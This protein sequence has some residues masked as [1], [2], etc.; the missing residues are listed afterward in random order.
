MAQR[1]LPQPQSSFETSLYIKVMVHHKK[2]TSVQ[3]KVCTQKQYHVPSAYLERWKNAQKRVSKQYCRFDS[4]KQQKKRGSYNARQSV[5]KNGKLHSKPEITMYD[6][7][8]MQP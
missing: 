1:A 4:L 7:D 6:F 3:K 8:R 5:G 2:T